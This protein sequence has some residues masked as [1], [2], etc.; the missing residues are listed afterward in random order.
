MNST[1]FTRRTVRKYE[2]KAIESALLERI[3]TA[4]TRA[5]TTGN[6][7]VYSII[8]TRDQEMKRRMA[9]AHFNQP[10]VTEAPVVLTFCADFNR[11]N[12]WCRQREAE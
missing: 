4:G 12:I 10:M 2:E 7:Q 1:Y 8:V 11:F 6:M 5:S 3:L 9:P